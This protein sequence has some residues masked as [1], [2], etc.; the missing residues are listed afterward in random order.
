VIARIPSVKAAIADHAIWA[1]VG[2]LDHI[3]RA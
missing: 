2:S 1:P 3:V